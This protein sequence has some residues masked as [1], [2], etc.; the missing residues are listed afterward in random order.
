MKFNVL[1]KTIIIVM[2]IFSQ[3]V[4]AQTGL[5]ER[6]I[7]LDLQIISIDS[8]FQHVAVLAHDSLQGRDTGSPGGKKAAQYLA[9]EMQKV[10]LKPAGDNATFFQ[11][12]P[13]HGSIPTSESQ[14]QLVSNRDIMK[15]ILWQ[16]YI[17]YNTGAQTFIP[18]PLPLVFVG[19]GIFAPEFDYND[20]QN[21]DIRNKIVVF[22]SGEPISEDKSYFDGSL[23]T[24]Y[25]DPVMKHRIALSRG[26]RGSILIPSP[27]EKTYMD[28][29]YWIRQFDFEDVKLMYG[30]SDNLNVL[31]NY[32]I[33]P[34]LFQNA[35]YR[36]DEIVQFDSNGTMRSFPLHLSAS[37]QGKF[38]ERDFVAQ[39]IIG[40][41]EGSDPLLQDD[42]VIVS[43][44]YDHLGIGMS[45]EGDSIYN[46]VVD[47]AIGTASVIEL[48]RSLKNM[49]NP[50][51]RS[52]LFL[53]VTGEEK[54]LLG[55]KFYCEQP[56]VPLHKT[57]AAVNIDGLAILD[58]F[59]SITGIG[60]ETSTLGKTLMQV[61]KDLGLVV[62]PQPE[63]FNIRDPLFSSDQLSFA[64]VGIPSILIMEG[65]DYQNLSKEEGVAKFLD[66]GQKYYHSP[67][68]DLNQM[69]NK[70]AVKQHAQ[71]LLTFIHSVANTFIVPQWL[72]GTRF[73]N[74]R[75]QTIAERR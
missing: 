59:T 40:L 52:I 75:L 18:T 73:M 67:F 12:I 34:M 65:L 69:I 21:L 6:D 2:I 47:N 53:L 4:I 56:A 25:S 27:R 32:N 3:T 22:L 54:G 14:L 35:K 36:F 61:A 64:Q 24:I 26:A 39:N 9:N 66:W 31:I 45:V 50:P 29:E 62:V 16:D 23:P 55:S 58:K 41:L 28:W 46:G 72:P 49:S 42:Y 30:F 43:A 48:A 13:L 74:A 1:I 71:V 44:H 70:D 38:Q 11:N 51:K 20:Y 68:D 19:Y 57:I 5:S 33:A 7:V 15:L 63:I 8:I 10:G 17:L 60:S 37:F